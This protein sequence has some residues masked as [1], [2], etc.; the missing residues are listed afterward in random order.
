MVWRNQK[1][2]VLTY[3]HRSFKGVLSSP[4]P[5]P[6]PIP[7]SAWV[8]V[9]CEG[10]EWWAEWVSGSGAT[11][12]L[13]TLQFTLYTLHFTLDNLHLTL[14]TL[15]F[16]LFALSLH[17]MHYLWNLVI[18]LWWS[19]FFLLLSILLLS[20]WWFVLKGGVIIRELEWLQAYSRGVELEWDWFL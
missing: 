1:P 19:P 5:F 9:S 14:Y 10:M 16:T 12:T 3:D 2:P 7:S 15:H 6:H 13:N 17:S 18:G 20:D 4:P 8:S 11:F